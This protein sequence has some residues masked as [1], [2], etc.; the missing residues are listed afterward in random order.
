MAPSFPAAL[1]RVATRG[2]RRCVHSCPG[3]GS[4]RA[5]ATATDPAGSAQRA[6][7]WIPHAFR[8]IHTL[9]RTTHGWR[10]PC[11]V[12][13]SLWMRTLWNRSPI[14]TDRARGQNTDFEGSAQLLSNARNRLEALV[15]TSSS[16]HMCYMA[17]FVVFV[18]LVRRC[19]RDL[20]QRPGQEHVVLKT[21]T[22]GKYTRRM[23]PANVPNGRRSQPAPA[24]LWLAQASCPA[25]LQQ[26]SA[27][28]RV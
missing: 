2:A 14:F 17:G 26:R 3:R 24:P 28:C 10:E 25:Q 9:N 8:G 12:Q 20:S 18:F 21:H 7:Q 22:P 13:F 19:P 5:T 1:P 23:Y 27:P 15:K 6:A 16:K 11:G 4:H